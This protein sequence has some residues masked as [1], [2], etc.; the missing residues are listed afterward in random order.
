M[1]R[2]LLI[3]N[4]GE[5]V[6][7]IIRSAR[8]MGVTPVAVYSTADKD[9]PYL[10]EVES[11]CL[12][13]AAAARSYLDAEA[14]V[15]AARQQACSA[16][17]PGWGFLSEQAGFAALCEQHGI[18][19]VGPPPAILDLMGGKTP[20]KRRMGELGLAG[21]PGSDGPIAPEHAL[22]EAERIGFPVMIKAESGGGGRGLR[23]C[24]AASDV[25]EA[26]AAAAREAA[27]AFADPTLYLERYIEGGRHIEV[28]VLVD[29]WGQA[30]TLGERE[31]SVQRKHQKLIEESPSPALDHQTRADLE[32][33]VARACSALGYRGAGTVELLR[34][35]DGALYFI[36]M[37]ARL[38]VEHPVSELLTGVDLV[39][40]QLRIAAGQRIDPDLGQQRSGHA[41]ECR[42]NA[43]DPDQGFKPSPGKITR[44][45]LPVG[46]GIRV[47]THIVEG[48][49]IPP[50]YDS[51][52]AKVIVHA[53]NREL[54][55][56][57]MLGALAN[58]EVEGVATTIRFHEKVL[59]SAAFRSGVYD[60]RLVEQL[61]ASES[62]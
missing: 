37:N 3:A 26:V 40:W 59:R 33:R 21:V 23:I 18:S 8:A 13:P 10:R 43:E 45:C 14:L 55:I 38:Q 50:F 6:S 31:C 25:Q 58:F 2:R 12:G 5:V 36:E 51:L 46:D 15:Q 48:Y 35:Q 29:R 42:I 7:R 9:A 4:R 49:E 44:L 57:K 28:Q 20:A 47:D 32:T 27:A 39:A 1:F 19:F 24:R 17:H 16:L 41:L 56:E 52:I 30:V 54:A 62:S 22:R 61:Q 53:A 60:T 11:V 34:A